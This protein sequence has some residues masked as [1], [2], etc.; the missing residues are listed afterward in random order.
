MRKLITTIGAAYARA[1][2]GIATHNTT[3]DTPPTR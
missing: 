3:S 2:I 1:G